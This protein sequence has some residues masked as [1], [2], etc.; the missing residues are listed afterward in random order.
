LQFLLLEF[1]AGAQREY[2]QRRD[3]TANIRKESRQILHVRVH[4]LQFARIAAVPN[5][6]VTVSNIY[7]TQDCDLETLRF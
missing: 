2:H 7:Y 3:R 1:A 4:P 6:T 5:R